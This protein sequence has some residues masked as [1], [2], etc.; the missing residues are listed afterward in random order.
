MN[1]NRAT[2]FLTALAIVV[3]VLVIASVGVAS[4]LERPLQQAGAPTLVS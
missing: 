1:G 2:L 3:A 4:P